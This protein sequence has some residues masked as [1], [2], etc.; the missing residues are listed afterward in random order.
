MY[1]P[2]SKY[3]DEEF[4]PGLIYPS[5]AVVRSTA[6][7]GAPVPPVRRSGATRAT[8]AALSIRSEIFFIADGV[9]NILTNFRF[10]S[11]ALGITPNSQ[12]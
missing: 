2:D 11:R 8:R 10:S 3:V 4:G 1:M 6:F 7:A 9:K 12:R 5:S